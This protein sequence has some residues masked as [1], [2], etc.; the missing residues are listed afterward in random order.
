MAINLS[1]PLR[2]KSAQ[3]DELAMLKD[4]Q[5]NILKGHGRSHTA[6]LFLKFNPQKSNEVKS[7]LASLKITDALKQLNDT[8]AFKVT[9]KSGGLI[10]LCLLSASGYR[11]MGANN[12]APANAAF[13]AGMGSRQAILNDPQ[14]QKWDMH[15]RSEIHALIILADDTAALVKKAKR[16]LLHEMPAGVSLVGEEIGLGMRSLLSHGEGIEHFGYVDGRSQPL[17]LEEDIENERDNKDGISVWSPRFGLDTALVKDPANTSPT[18]FGSFFV[19]RKLEENVRGFKT[20][21][22][23]LASFLGLKGDDK[24]RAGAMIIGRFEN[25]SPVVLQRGDGINNPVPNNFNYKDDPTAAKCPFHGHIRKANPR[26][27]SVKA[28]IVTEAQERAHIMARRGIT[29]G[30]R[31]KHP[32]DETLKKSEMPTGK[33]GLLFMAYQSNIENQFE[34]TQATWVNN[35]DFVS[36]IFVT[37]GNVTGID[38][39]IG[40]GPNGGPAAPAGHFCPVKWGGGAATPRKQSDFQGFVKMLG[41]EYFF[42]PSLSTLKSL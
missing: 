7:W 5:A 9:K 2:W 41:G 35:K 19:F 32:N 25:G 36:P 40:Q 31:A 22:D 37:G 4:L 42:A 8:E 34:F 27:E 26:G 14:Q 10:T 38:P 39:V 33:V 20:A 17:M 12:L 24:E 15:F 29:Y 3:P 13:A 18:S 16:N 6:N 21:E 11:A 30:K 23:K 28:G 1:A